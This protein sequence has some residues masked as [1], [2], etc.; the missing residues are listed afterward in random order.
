MKIAILGY[1]KEWK[2]TFNWLLNQW[3]SKE[4]IDILDKS[5]DENYLDKLD[6]YDV[7]FKTPWISIYLPQIEKNIK[8]ITS[9][10]DIFFEKYKWKIILVTWSKWKSTTSTLVYEFFKKAGKNVKLVWNIW[11]PIFDEIDFSNQPDYVVFEISSYM[12]D[13]IKNLKADYSILTNIYEVHTWWH[14]THENYVKSKIKAVINSKLSILRKDTYERVKSLLKKDVNVILFWEG[15]DY[16]FDNEFVYWKTYKISKNKIFLWGEHNYLNIVSIFPI[17]EKENISQDIVEEVLKNFKWLEH[18][19]EFVWE[20]NWVKFY[21]DSIATIPESILQALNRF[22]EDLDTIILWWQDNWFDY[23]EV[24]KKINSLPLENV[25]LLPNSFDWLEDS[26]VNKK[27]FKVNDLKSA[28][29]IAKKETKSGKICILSPGAPSYNL[30]KN[31]EERW[32]LFKE[33]VKNN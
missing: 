26:F 8:K 23:S 32:K 22:K 30:F 25:I 4:Q 28:V 9:Q 19:Q 5:I 2:S 12:L 3:Y 13:S 29:N 15:T 6:N 14:K 21:N 7:I 16:F 11:N 20:I 10:A 17:L 33:Y 27:V 31:F 1:W 18:R 24:I